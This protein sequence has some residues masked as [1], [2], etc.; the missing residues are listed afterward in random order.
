[1][2]ELWQAVVLGVVQGFTEFF[3]VSSDGH[4][5]MAEN[6]LGLKIPGLLFTM[7][8][9]IATLLSVVIVFR[10]KIL[11]LIRG[12]AG[13]GEES[14]WR[15]IM[16]VVAATI[17]AIIVGFFFKDWFETTFEDVVFTGTMILVTGSVVWST[18]WARR[19][20]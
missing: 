3:P 15:Y 13:K 10:D 9:H 1:M 14:S 4:L 19:D 2:M 11:K 20:H 5:V 16:K 18:R 6:L 7:A 17:P 12:M 8:V